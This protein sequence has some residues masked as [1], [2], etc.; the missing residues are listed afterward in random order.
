MPHSAA[1][2]VRSEIPAPTRY[3]AVGAAD[4]GAGRPG[5]TVAAAASAAVAAPVRASRVRRSIP[6]E[7]VPVTAL[8]IDPP[9]L[10]VAANHTTGQTSSDDAGSGELTERVRTA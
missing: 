6:G 4:A 3:P 5:A 1:G 8:R 7:R 10:Q 2:P 9:F